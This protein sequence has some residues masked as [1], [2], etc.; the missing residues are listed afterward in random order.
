MSLVELLKHVQNFNVG[1]IQPPSADAIRAMT[2]ADV[3][4]AIEALAPAARTCPDE[5]RLSTMPSFMPIGN[6]FN[7][8]G[9]EEFQRL[10][11][12]LGLRAAP[13]AL[14]VLRAYFESDR[15]RE[16]RLAAGHY[17][18]M[19][20]DTGEEVAA[21]AD[22]MANELV[23]WF[24]LWVEAQISISRTEAYAPIAARVVATADRE[25]LLQ[26]VMNAGWR[27]AIED[28]RWGELARQMLAIDP[29]HD[30][31]LSVVANVKD[32]SSVS[33]LVARAANPDFN[34]AREALGKL[35]QILDGDAL[36]EAL[37]PA[38]ATTSQKALFE[39][40]FVQKRLA[41]GLAIV[42]A[43]KR[44]REARLARLSFPFRFYGAGHTYEYY[45]VGWLR[46]V[47]RFVGS[48]DPATK[49]KVAKTIAEEPAACELS[50]TP[51]EWLEQ[52]GDTWAAFHHEGQPMDMPF[53][54]RAIHDV[55][56]IRLAML[57]GFL[58]DGEEDDWTS[59]SRLQGVCDDVPSIE[60]NE[61]EAFEN[62]RNET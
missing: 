47:V 57:D 6:V 5:G 37:V 35:A 51:W 4:E 46:Y 53:V 22:A 3:V 30:S 18:L 40:L 41:P 20:P 17:M 28:S 61:D 56:P 52:D 21:T 48:L 1:F 25:P 29:G 11:Y 49:R 43:R 58:Q 23:G 24:R 55:V 32:T 50:R 9:C 59:W 14:P 26:A 2:A 13:E 36:F 15:S 8:T 33:L 42:E 7:R 39:D 60:G 27:H 54:L 12:M 62:V 45:D 44:E 31:A 38:Y 34:T 19:F 10:G 16:V